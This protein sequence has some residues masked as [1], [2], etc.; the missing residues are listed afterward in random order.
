MTFNPSK[1]TVPRY[2]IGF[3]PL[4]SN[5]SYSRLSD[6]HHSFAGFRIHAERHLQPYVMNVYLPTGALVAI[7]FIGFLIPVE[8]IP[9]RMALIITIFL[10]LINVSASERYRGPLVS[11]YVVGG[12]LKYTFNCWALLP[13][14]VLCAYIHCGLNTHWKIVRV[15]FYALWRYRS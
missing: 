7:S 14:W 1:A 12:G 6:E 4:K 8:Q 15:S 2:A 13:K 11:K 10:M 3:H 5:L 9:G